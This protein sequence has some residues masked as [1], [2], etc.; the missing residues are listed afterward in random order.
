MFNRNFDSFFWFIEISYHINNI[1]T[2][3]LFGL[4]TMGL[5]GLYTEPRPY[6]VVS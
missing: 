5:F 1:S 6:T 4:Y 3:V 2:L